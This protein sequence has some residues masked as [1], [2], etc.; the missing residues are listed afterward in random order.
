MKQGTLRPEEIEKLIN[1]FEKNKYELERIF[2][3]FRQTVAQ[4]SKFHGPIVWRKKYPD[5]MICLQGFRLLK[6][7]HGNPEV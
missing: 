2:S 1:T 4:A 5:L 3:D 6:K 7:S